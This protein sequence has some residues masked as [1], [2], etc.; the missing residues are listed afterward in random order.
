MTQN[1][2]KQNDNS[3]RLTNFLIIGEWLTLVGLFVT[4]FFLIQGQINDQAK[5]SD[6]LYSQFITLVKAVK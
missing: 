2:H 1:E 5:R 6:D 4:A 3:S